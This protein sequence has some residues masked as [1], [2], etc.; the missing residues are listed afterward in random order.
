[1]MAATLAKGET[2]ISEA[3]CEP[4]IVDLAK[5][6]NAMGAKIE[7]AGTAEVG[8]AACR[9]CPGR[10]PHPAGPHRVRHLCHGRGD[11]RRTHRA[12]ARPARAVG[13]GR[14]K[15]AETG[16]ELEATA[17][18]FIAGCANGGSREATS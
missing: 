7:G 14:E 11:H 10:A 13:R 17:D 12:E 2:V 16:V 18:G 1:M 15:L 3:A 6:L 8:S 5:C 9:A 4:E